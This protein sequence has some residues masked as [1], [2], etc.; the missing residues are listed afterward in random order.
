MTLATRCSACGTVFRVVEDQLRASAGWVRCGRCQAVFNAVEHLVDVGPDSPPFP[1]TPGAL[2][3]YRDS[4]LGTLERVARQRAPAPGDDAAAARDDETAAG[5][6]AGATADG[7][8]GAR[9]TAGTAA[10]AGRA[11]TAAAGWPGSAGGAARI[12]GSPAVV[13][14]RPLVLPAH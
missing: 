6:E 13:S 3:A 7:A 10:T 4:V 11:A 8:A 2:S 1:T 12:P 5:H 14:A 9:A